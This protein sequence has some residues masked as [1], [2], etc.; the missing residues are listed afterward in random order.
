MFFSFPYNCVVFHPLYTVNNQGPFFIAANMVSLSQAAKDIT[1]FGKSMW[2][3]AT[4]VCPPLVGW[5]RRV[6]YVVLTNQC[7]FIC[8]EC[9]NEK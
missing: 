3:E 2:K 9:P 1:N 4:S 6:V 5:N 7:R 8:G